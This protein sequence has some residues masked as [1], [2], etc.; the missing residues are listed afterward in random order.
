MRYKF[1]ALFGIL[2]LVTAG[3]VVLARQTPD[4]PPRLKVALF[5]YTTNTLPPPPPAL[6]HLYPMPSGTGAVMKIARIEVLNQGAR[7]VSLNGG[8]VR[9]R[10]NGKY[11]NPAWQ[12][13]L[14][15]T[16]GK[17]EPGHKGTI[18]VGF[19]EIAG[20]HVANQDPLV[21]DRV[22]LCATCVATKG[23]D[24]AARRLR[25]QTWSRYLP[26]FLLGNQSRVYVGSGVFV[27]A[28]VQQP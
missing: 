16:F 21:R 11:S 17:V 8:F 20:R 22:D 6:R 19:P 4:S 9:C 2:L 7:A 18:V 1:F 3:V 23:A 10:I 12:R 15:G 14:G 24:S 25:A 26:R 28:W 13:V 5:C 27:S